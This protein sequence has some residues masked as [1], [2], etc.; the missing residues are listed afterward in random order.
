MKAVIRKNPGLNFFVGFIG[1]PEIPTKQD[2][3]KP[4]KGFRVILEDEGKR[5]DL[6]QEYDIYIKKKGKANIQEFVQKFSQQ[7]KDNLSDEHPYS[8]D[9]K[10]EVIV[11]VSMDEKRLKEVDIDNLVKCVLDCFNGL[12]YEDDSQIVN[13]LGSKDVNSFFP[14]NMLF[15]GI[16][17]IKDNNE[18]WFKNIKLASITDQE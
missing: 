6:S 15:V 17:K 11:S 12:V 4:L 18:S 2:K 10:L 16:R 1:G 13:I 9:T 3:F 8:R 5:T 7:I 14:A